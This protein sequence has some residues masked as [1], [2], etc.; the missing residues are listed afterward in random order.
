MTERK[1]DRLIVKTGGRVFFVKCDDIDWIEAA[2]NY[3]RLHVGSATHMLRETMSSLERRLDPDR[4]FRTHRSQIVNIDRV[5]EL[6]SSL[7]G[8]YVVRLTNGVEL[9]LTRGYR[10]RLRERLGVAF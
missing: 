4:F 10:E 8:E 7:H 3:V 5:Q 1:L 6:Q 2:G 9:I